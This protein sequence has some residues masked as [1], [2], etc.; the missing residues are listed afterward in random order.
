MSGSGASVAWPTAQARF[1]A[2]GRAAR[3]RAAAARYAARSPA[4]SRAVA[5][6][7]AHNFL[8]LTGPPEMGKTAIARMLG[9]ELLTEGWEVHAP[10]SPRL[11]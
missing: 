2:V 9:M 5:T 6:L 4:W 7:K 10:R 8:V 1:T 11:S 3:M